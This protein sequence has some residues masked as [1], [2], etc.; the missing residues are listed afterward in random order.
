LEVLQE[1][2]HENITK[3]LETQQES[4]L[5]FLEVLELDGAVILAEESEL[6]EQALLRRRSR[7]VVAVNEVALP[8]RQA[9]VR[10]TRWKM[11]TAEREQ[12]LSISG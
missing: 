9:G 5:D 4:A 7:V 10:R 8:K 12:Y 11:T 1:R 2:A 6:V 3:L